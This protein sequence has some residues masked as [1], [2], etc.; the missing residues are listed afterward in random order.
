[1]KEASVTFTFKFLAG[2]L[3]ILLNNHLRELISIGSTSYTIKHISENKTL[4]PTKLN[5]HTYH[6]PTLPDENRFKLKS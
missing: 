4:E 6:N 5:R 1:M 3:K 2:R